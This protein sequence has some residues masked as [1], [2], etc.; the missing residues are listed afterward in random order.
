M[1]KFLFVYRASME[2][3]QNPPSPE[4]MQAELAAWQGW[5]AKLGNAVVDAGDG[6]LPTGRVLNGTVVTD[7]PYIETK[8]IVGGYSIVSADSYTAAIE[9][10][11]GCP[12]LQHGGTLEIRQL[13]G[14]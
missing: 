4:A 12:I 9:F 7:G 2:S 6:L 5:L 8:E 1:A 13:A 3:E 10:A 11:N 14:F